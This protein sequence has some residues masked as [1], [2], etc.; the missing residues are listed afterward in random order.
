MGTFSRVAILGK[1]VTEKR[2][3]ATKQAAETPEVADGAR[4]RE[5]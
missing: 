5:S 1:R 2:A 3:T 4:T